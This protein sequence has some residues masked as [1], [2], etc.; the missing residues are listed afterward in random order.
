MPHGQ[1]IMGDFD[2][3]ASNIPGINS[4]IVS[5]KGEGSA[6]KRDFDSYLVERGAAD[7][8]FP[9]DFDMLKVMHEAVLG[10]EAEVRKSYEFF[11]EFSLKEWALSK[12]GFNPI[13]E[14]FSNTSF[15]LSRI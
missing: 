9:V 13:K 2:S 4:P 7:I 1:L 15:L 12:S 14:D 10:R 3:L 6:E 11:D 5:R 8:F